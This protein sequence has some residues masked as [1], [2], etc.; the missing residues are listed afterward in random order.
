MTE[1]TTPQAAHILGIGFGNGGGLLFTQVTL[2]IINYTLL[3]YYRWLCFFHIQVLLNFPAGKHRLDSNLLL[4]AMYF[5]QKAPLGY[6]SF[7]GSFAGKKCS[8]I[9]HATN[10]LGQRSVPGKF[11]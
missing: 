2:E 7:L 9:D 8:C 10:C 4:R 1:F 6:S 5:P 3:I 11:K